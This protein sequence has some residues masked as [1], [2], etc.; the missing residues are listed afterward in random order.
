[1]FIVS[2]IFFISATFSPAG[3]WAKNE[4]NL[5]VLAMSKSKWLWELSSISCIKYQQGVLSL[6]VTSTSPLSL[7]NLWPT[8]LKQNHIGR[9]LF[10]LW[11][12][13]QCLRLQW[14][15]L[16]MSHPCVTIRKSFYA[17]QSYFIS[18]PGSEAATKP[19]QL[20][21]QPMTVN[22]KPQYFPGKLN[23]L[24]FQTNTLQSVDHLSPQQNNKNYEFRSSK[25]VGR[26]GGQD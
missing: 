24:T 12:T 16:D 21:V 7:L 2:A 23:L 11:L 4:D 20:A 8:S 22:V 19:F 10:L 17:R 26:A 14:S 15:R 5:N 1:M 3:S 9:P 6:L 25:I 13:S 18:N